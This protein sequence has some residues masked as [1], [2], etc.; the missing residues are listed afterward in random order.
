MNLN[1]LRQSFAKIWPSLAL[2]IPTYIRVTL[3]AY[4]HIHLSQMY[5]GPHTHTHTHVCIYI[6]TYIYTHVCVYIYVYKTQIFPR[7]AR[8]PGG[9]ELSHYRGFT[10]TLRHTTIVKTPL[11]EWS[12]RRRSLDLA[13]HNTHKRQ[14]SMPSAVFKST[15]PASERPQSHTSDQCFPTFVRRRPSK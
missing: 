11:D 12:V 4:V 2:L 1:L 13:T 9:P 10:I 6:Y 8:I 5:V 14:T 3:C 7:G 15:V